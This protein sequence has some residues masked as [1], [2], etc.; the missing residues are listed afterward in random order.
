[1]SRLARDGN[2]E[3]VSRD[4]IIRHKRGQ[5]NMTI[6]TYS[7]ACTFPP[8]IDTHVSNLKHWLSVELDYS[9]FSRLL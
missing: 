8:N 5:E 3:H 1:M 7:I 6:H 9:Y 2:A 4:K